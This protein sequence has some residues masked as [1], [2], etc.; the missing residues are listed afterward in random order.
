MPH[1]SCLCL[2]HYKQTYGIGGGR[3]GKANIKNS[4]TDYKYAIFSLL[5]YYN[6]NYSQK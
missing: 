5:K 6:K 3:E 1:F 2:K 4:F